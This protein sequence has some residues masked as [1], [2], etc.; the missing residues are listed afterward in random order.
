MSATPTAPADTTAAPSAKPS[1]PEMAEPVSDLID[2]PS[3]KELNEVAANT[4]A[5]SRSVR[6]VVLA[7]PVDSGKTTLLTSLYELFQWGTV[8]DQLFAGSTTLP[9]FEQ[10]CHLA[11]TVSGGEIADTGRKIGRAHV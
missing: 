3:G 9:A 1:A 2:L 11:R 6:V 8:A 7:G 5:A 4:I 10:R